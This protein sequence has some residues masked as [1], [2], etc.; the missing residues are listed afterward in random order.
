[1]NEIWNDPPRL[2]LARP[3]E[4]REIEALYMSQIGHAM[5]DWNEAYP[6]IEFIQD[7]LANGWLYVLRSGG[8]IAATVSLLPEEELDALPCWSP[9]R[10]LFAARLCVARD[11]QGRG[12]AGR[13]MAALEPIALSRGAK[14]LRLLC[15]VSNPVANRVYPRAGYE[16]RGKAHLFDRDFLCYEKILTNA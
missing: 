9:G 16:M 1:M 8:R 14:A 7:D 4:A 13:V 2:S 15:S 6:S 10:S 5:S 3:E 11:L 12:L